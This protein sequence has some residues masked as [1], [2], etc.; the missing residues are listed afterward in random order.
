MELKP[1]PQAPRPNVESKRIGPVAPRTVKPAMLPVGQAPPA[2]QPMRSEDSADG[3]RG[4]EK[5]GR[6]GQA[7]RR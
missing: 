7:R 4:R 3:S 5:G 6:P 2:S 1:F